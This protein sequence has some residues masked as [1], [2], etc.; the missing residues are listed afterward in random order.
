MSPLIREDD[1][2]A[3]VAGMLLFCLAV[4]GAVAV[5]LAPAQATI[6]VVGHFHT[7]PATIRLRVRVEPD[8][9]N[10][11]LTTVIDADGFYTSSDED[12][13]ARS[14]PTR[15]VEFRDVPEG[16]YAATAV[17]QRVSGRPWRARTAFVVIGP[18][19]GGGPSP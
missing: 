3:F 10:Q 17:V 5:G 19:G 4:V 9:A 1:A 13:T 7:A 12:L 8:A 16:F 2:P 14:R 6:T 11:L 15:W 18:L